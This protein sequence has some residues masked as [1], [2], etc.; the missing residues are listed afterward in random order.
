MAIP[1]AN[2][3]F[4]NIKA[5]L[6]QF[7]KSQ[8]E[9]AD[10]D[11]TGSAMNI[12]LDV[13]A[14]S[15]HYMTVYANM[16][17]NEMFLDT[18]QLRSSVVSKA[19]EIGYFP[20]QYTGSVSSLDISIDLSTETTPP[21]NVTIPK[22]TKFTGLY[23][24]GESYTFS[25][26]ATYILPNIGGNI[27][28][29]NINIIQG[30]YVTDIFTYDSNTPSSKMILSNRKIDTNE[31]TVVVRDFAGSSNIVEYK[32]ETNITSA[33]STSLIYFLQEESDGRI[34]IM[35]GNGTIGRQLLDGEVVE[36]TYL[37]TEGS[38]AN[39]IS[40]FSVNNNIDN[41]A[42]NRF[43]IS[44]V[45]KSSGGDDREN[46]EEIRIN[47]PKN[48]QTQNR[49]VTVQDYRSIILREVSNISSVNVWGGE[50][51]TPQA[52][53][54]LRMS[55][56]TKDGT[57]LTPR[58]KQNILDT[59]SKFN[60][61]T[62]TPEIIDPQQL[63]LDVQS[64]VSYDY[65]KTTLRDDDI[66]GLVTTQIRNYFVAKLLDFDSTFR[67][68]DFVADIDGSDV[69]VLGNSTSIILAKQH[70]S[71]VGSV[72]LQFDFNNALEPKS[73]KSLT[74]VDDGGSN[75]YLFDDGNGKVFEN[76][77]GIDYPTAI[78]T[79][80]Y[81]TGIVTID[82]Y[83]FKSTNVAIR[84]RAKPVN[85]DIVSARNTL[86]EEGIHNITITRVL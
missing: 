63:Y 12:L 81:N 29:E 79:I 78:G 24:N 27:Y 74:W 33:T 3:D 6:I 72:S 37:V 17:F 41:W 69:S 8:N 39:Q 19:K 66:L 53:G 40:N 38:K 18:A 83:D 1:V 82:G 62:I 67:Y 56:R 55:I 42:S 28:S 71:I 58:K 11:F 51:D 22:G 44:N 86:L 47:A 2:S 10:F 50:E 31:M 49:C 65:Q 75:I 85:L 23:E 9:F 48:Y 76:V 30:T 15:S 35:F 77:N 36:V 4:D 46:I 60:I 52:F 43:K 59:I 26:D 14:Y 61:I 54:K 57:D 25:S 21:T 32:L 34:R 16:T 7:L 70:T 73:F 64:N 80:D 5:D 68:S 45:V 84:L 13:L 20:K